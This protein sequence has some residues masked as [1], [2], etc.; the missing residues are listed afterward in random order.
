MN[1]KAIYAKGT[2]D[3]GRQKCSSFPTEVRYF[4]DKVWMV[5]HFHQQF[6]LL[7]LQPSSSASLHKINEMFYSKNLS[8]YISQLL[9]CGQV[10][11]A[12]TMLLM[13]L[14]T[15]NIQE[16]MFVPMQCLGNL[17]S[18]LGPLKKASY[19]CCRSMLLFSALPYTLP[20]KI[21]SAYFILHSFGAAW[22]PV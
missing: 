5:L 7:V 11:S 16:I 20:K 1:T 12:T 19:P 10:R 22:K 3:F 13:A 21:W 4:E 15:I 9:S 6:R 17:I 14:L 8:P 18:V 2:R